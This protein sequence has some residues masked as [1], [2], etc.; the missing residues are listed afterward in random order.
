[1]GL[2][3]ICSGDAFSWD[4]Q[5]L[6]P[7]LLDLDPTYCQISSPLHI[8]LSELEQVALNFTSLPHQ[9]TGAKLLAAG[10]TC[11]GG[12]RDMR[13]WPG[14]TC[15]GGPTA[16]HALVTGATCAGG[17]TA[18][19]ALVARRRD[20]RWWPARHALVARRRDMRWRPRGR[21]DM[22]WWPAQPADGNCDGAASTS[23]R[24]AGSR[25]ALGLALTSGPLSPAFRI[26]GQ[27]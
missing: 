4:R 20:M 1:M 8:S 14:A 12:G 3:G 19:H 15:A 25:R 24:R 10:E 9:A 7:P 5:S 13:W 17:P 23:R 11:A 27:P 26:V 22:R 16:R 6:L 18:R 21:R 2:F